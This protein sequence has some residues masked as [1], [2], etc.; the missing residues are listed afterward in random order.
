MRNML[1]QMLWILL[2]AVVLLG[3]IA[4]NFWYYGAILSS[5]LPGWAKFLLL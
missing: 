1:P 3:G 5:D 4:L 2:I